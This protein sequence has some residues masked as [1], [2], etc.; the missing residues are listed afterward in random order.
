MVGLVLKNQDVLTA[1]TIEQPVSSLDGVV[2]SVRACSIVDLPQ[3]KANLRHFVAI[4][5]R[6][7]GSVDSHGSEEFAIGKAISL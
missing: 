3:S 4:V 1:S 5:Q 6:N 7:V 2:D